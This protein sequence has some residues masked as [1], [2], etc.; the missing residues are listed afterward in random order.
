MVE[1]LQKSQRSMDLSQS[2]TTNIGISS[3]QR[4]ITNLYVRMSEGVRFKTRKHQDGIKTEIWCRDQ[5]WTTVLSSGARIL[6]RNSSWELQ[7]TGLESVISSSCVTYLVYIG[8]HQIALGHDTCFGNE[9]KSP[10]ILYCPDCWDYYDTTVSK[11]CLNCR[12]CTKDQDCEKHMGDCSLDHC[13]LS[14]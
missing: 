3:V 9:S 10:T 8:G 13:G 2:T 11:S 4:G 12:K 6:Q 14:S 5:K 1:T 7:F